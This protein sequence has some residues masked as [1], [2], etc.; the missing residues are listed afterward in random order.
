MEQRLGFLEQR[1]EFLEQMLGPSA[2]SSAESVVEL[3]L[4][5]F[6]GF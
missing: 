2:G 1:L 4:V 6:E 3:E 5:V